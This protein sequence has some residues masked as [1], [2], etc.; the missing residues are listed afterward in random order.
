[1]KPHVLGAF[2]VVVAGGAVSAGCGAR[3]PVP[4]T[5]AH[6][7]DEPVI[8]PYPPP[9]A[10]PEIVPPVNVPGEG[11]VWVDGEWDWRGTRWVWQEGRWE[12]P[13]GSYYA[14]PV[15]IRLADGRLAWFRGSW[16]Q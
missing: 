5:G 14:R 11:A 16:H 2:L 1:M 15:M 12:I 13:P 8:V 10:R 3:L 9:P 4:P 6:I 7:G